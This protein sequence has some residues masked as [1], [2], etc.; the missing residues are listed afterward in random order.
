MQEPLAKGNQKRKL[1]EADNN[2]YGSN[3]SKLETNSFVNGNKMKK[4][5][6][7]INEDNEESDSREEDNLSEIEVAAE[8][9]TIPDDITQKCKFQF[10][11]ISDILIC[12]YY[13]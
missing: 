9:E 10:G 1:E 5:K 2:F 11:N 7:R 4:R 3:D 12:F 6:K 13:E 8:G